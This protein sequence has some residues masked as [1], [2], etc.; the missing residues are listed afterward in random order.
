MNEE[1]LK[2]LTTKL[3]EFLNTFLGTDQQFVWY[4]AED[5]SLNSEFFG[6]SIETNEENEQMAVI[7]FNDGQAT[8]ILIK[9]SETVID[10]IEEYIEL[11]CYIDICHYLKVNKEGQVT[12]VLFENEY[13][14]G[15]KKSK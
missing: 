3:D 10:L 6:V 2:E 12:E 13:T 5:G 7:S 4:D 14:K 9:M 11:P 8:S 1:R 15:F